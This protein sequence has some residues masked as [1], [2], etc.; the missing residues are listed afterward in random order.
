MA[1]CARVFHQEGRASDVIARLGEREVAVLAP[2]T[3]EGGAIKMAERF[4]RALRSQVRD[5]G[6]EGVQVD[7]SAV[8][9]TVTDLSYVA[10]RPIDLVVHASSSLRARP[11]SD[12]GPWVRR[13]GGHA[14]VGQ[15]EG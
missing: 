3:D 5:P 12:Q 9:E 14:R 10:V 2:R 11:Q 15:V 4:A 13:S 7:L 6:S 1:L 8:Y